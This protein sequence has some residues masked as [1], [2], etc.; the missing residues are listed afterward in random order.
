MVKNVDMFIVVGYHNRLA[1]KS[2]RHKQ[3]LWVVIRI[4]K[5]EERLIRIATRRVD[6]GFMPPTRKL[7]YRRLEKRIKHLKHQYR[8]GGRSLEQYWAAV[9]HVVGQYA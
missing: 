7:K 6:M 3:S 4:L 2:D 8:R 5:D 9:T 1:E